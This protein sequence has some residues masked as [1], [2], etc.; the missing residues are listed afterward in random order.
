MVDFK[1]LLADRKYKQ[2]HH[3]DK[4]QILLTIDNKTIGCLSSF[5]I[6]SGVPKSGKSTYIGATIGSAIKRDPVFKIALQPIPERQR[7]CLFDTE[8]SEFD[9]YKQIDKINYFGEVQELPD[10]IDCFNCREDGADTIQKLIETYLHHRP[11]CSILIIDGLLDLL[12]DYNDVRESRNLINWLK[13]ITKI[14]NILVIGVLHLGKKDLQTL[15]HFGSQTDRYAQSTLKIEKNKDN[16]TYC[17]SPSF[18]RSSDDFT[19]IEVMWNNGWYQTSTDPIKKHT[20]KDWN[21][22]EHKRKAL[23][24]IGGSGDDYNEIVQYLKEVESIGTNAAKAIVKLW[25]SKKIIVK[26]DKKYIVL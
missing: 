5:V 10:H 3:P 20:Y 22:I 1:K 12:I 23:Q 8:S 24:I 17:L 14:Y 11:D 19:P 7:I 18:L 26:R 9:F 16:N 2:N 15:G 25:I 4:E 21:D 13:K 6:Y